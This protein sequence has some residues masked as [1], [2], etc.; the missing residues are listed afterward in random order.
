[1]KA[2]AV[3]VLTVCLFFVAGCSSTHTIVTKDGGTIVT[4][5]EPK[6]DDDDAFYEYETPD[7][8][9]GKI[10]KDEVK[11]IDKGVTQPVE[12]P[13]PATPAPA[14]AAPA[15]AQAAPAPATPAPAPATPA[16]APAAQPG[17]TTTK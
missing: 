2:I 1:M 8:K 5:G 16:P 6:F 11:R 14:Q 17:T 10:N 12:K 7:G 13:A 3:L 4:E 15:P 9:S